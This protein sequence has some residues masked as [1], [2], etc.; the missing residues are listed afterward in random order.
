MGVF[1]L[2]FTGVRHVEG[3]TNLVGDEWLYEEVH[4]HAEGEFDYQVMFW[5]S[6]FRVVADDIEVEQLLP[7]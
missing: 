5:R 6:D 4:L 7:A 3:V 1:R 2:C